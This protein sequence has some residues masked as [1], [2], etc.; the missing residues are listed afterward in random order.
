MGFAGDKA[1]IV[2]NGSGKVEIVDR[3][4]FK[5][6]AEPII[7]SYPRYFQA[8]NAQKGYLTNGKLQGYVYIIDLENNTIRDSVRTGFGPET[9]VKLGDEVFVANSGGWGT[10]STISV[11][12]SR[13]DSVIATLTVGDIPLDMAL[14]G[15]ND[16][17]V[18]CKGH[19][20]YS[21][22][23]PYDLI[24]ET[25]ASL[26]KINTGTYSILWEGTVGYAG[27]YTGTPPKLAADAD[28]N[29]IY[30]L[31]PDGVYRIDAKDPS[32]PG[33]RILEG[34]FYGLDVN[35]GNGDLYVFQSSFTSNGTLFVVDPVTG[36]KEPFTVGIGPNGAIFNLK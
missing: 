26:V 13:Y 30:F 24:G 29:I 35:P 34:S 19:A 9:M 31:R 18:Y 28:G 36:S 8:V 5:T 3:E 33:D 4:T 21:N 1:Y 22:E 25:E 2:V 15:E 23:P 20:T 7:A 32:L 12:D 27:D 17:W 14:D 10:D 16:L 6:A 11:I